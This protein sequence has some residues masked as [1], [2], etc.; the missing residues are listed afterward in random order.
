L[1]APRR[2][3]KHK[4]VSVAESAAQIGLGHFENA[5]TLHIGA[6]RLC[7]RGGEENFSFVNVSPRR[8]LSRR[9]GFEG[10]RGMAAR[11]GRL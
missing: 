5:P 2:S 10:M 11:A 3:A 1:R 7:G 6:G 9:G 8:L 4:I